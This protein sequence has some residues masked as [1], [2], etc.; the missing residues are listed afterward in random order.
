M[1]NQEE[2]LKS[3][4]YCILYDIQLWSS[5]I[6]DRKYKG[7][8]A[9]CFSKMLQSVN[10]HLYDHP[11]LLERQPHGFYSDNVAFLPTTMYDRM[12]DCEPLTVKTPSINSYWNLTGLLFIPI[13]TEMIERK[14]NESFSI[15]EK[16]KILL[17]ALEHSFL[18]DSNLVNNK[19]L[20][21]RDSVKLSELKLN[22]Q[23][24]K[25]ALSQEEVEATF[26]FEITEKF[27]KEAMSSIWTSKMATYLSK[28]EIIKLAKESG[29]HMSRMDLLENLT[30]DTGFIDYALLKTKD[31]YEKDSPLSSLVGKISYPS[32]TIDLLNIDMKTY[33]NLIND[34]FN[35]N[36]YQILTAFENLSSHIVK[37]AKNEQDLMRYVSGIWS[38]L[39]MRLNDNS[40]N[41]AITI[42]YEHLLDRFGITSEQLNKKIIPDDLNF[43]IA[44]VINE[45]N[46]CTSTKREDLIGVM[47]GYGEMMPTVRT[48]IFL[49]NTLKKT[50]S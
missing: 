32:N 31:I 45:N 37:E 10:I 36:R 16:E 27:I 41:E 17:S 50:L 18:P 23:K 42:L 4:D 44:F 30:S 34:P 1:Q 3:Q 6:L 2:F 5:N 11:T 12:K 47:T 15:E 33:E 24:I 38:N 46:L 9:K 21:Y 22:N 13:L 28:E 25:T 19:T 26:S 40:F 20:S 49:N 29:L 43:E 39:A 48:N 14:Y 7:P 8:R 35:S